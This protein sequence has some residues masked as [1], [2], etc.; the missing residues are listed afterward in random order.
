MS[1]RPT[2][3]D[4]RL[5]QYLASVG[6][7]EHPAQAALRAAT[8]AL[9]EGGMRSATEQVALLA[10]LVETLTARR[11]LEIGCFTGY[12]ALAMALALPP[13]GHVVTLE[14]DARWPEI[15]RPHWRAAGVEERIDLRLGLALDT[16]AQLEAEAAAGSFD[17]AYVDADKKLYRDYLEAALKLIRPGG[18]VALDNVLWN[19]S[20]A[21]P[22]DQSHQTAALR[23]LN[24]AIHGDPRVTMVLLPIGDGLTL[25]RKR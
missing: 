9:A 17:L 24:A 21:D 16:L 1:P 14:A 6:W 12:G 15:G 11:V 13:D 20:V 5:A 8:D 3:I 23:E 7:R 10:F 2:P 22:A 19:G 4:D 25:C 18:I